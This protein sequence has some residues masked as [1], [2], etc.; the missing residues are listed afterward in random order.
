[1][2][3]LMANAKFE[4]KLARKNPHPVFYKRSEKESN[5][6]VIKSVKEQTQQEN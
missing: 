3:N 5:S 1:M 2:R 4:I 6:M